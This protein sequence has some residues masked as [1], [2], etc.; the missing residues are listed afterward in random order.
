MPLEIWWSE[1][2]FHRFSKGSNQ[3]LGCSR[4]ITVET[5]MKE[6]R[7]FLGSLDRFLSNELILSS[8]AC[9]GLIRQSFLTSGHFKR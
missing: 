4:R 7:F 9:K 3:L 8:L 5:R 1:E 6:A 2:L